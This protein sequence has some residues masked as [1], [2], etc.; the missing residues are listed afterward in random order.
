MSLEPGKI[1]LG[2]G[3]VW[4]DGQDIKSPPHPIVRV[5]LQEKATWEREHPNS[6]PGIPERGDRRGVSSYSGLT[7]ARSPRPP[8]ARGTFDE[9]ENRK[10]MAVN[11]I[12]G[13]PRV[14]CM[15]SLKWSISD[16]V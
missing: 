16:Q 6:M 13:G 12:R 3:R 14:A 9:H 8:R 1:I 15:W 5:Q 2:L 10:T 7:E 4:P 11:E